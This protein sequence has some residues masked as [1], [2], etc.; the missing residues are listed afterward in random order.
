MA[1]K[2]FYDEAKHAGETVHKQYVRQMIKYE[3]DLEFMAEQL[4][5][6]ETDF[7]A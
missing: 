4:G 2:Y 6:E 1:K 3:F 7:F 5:F